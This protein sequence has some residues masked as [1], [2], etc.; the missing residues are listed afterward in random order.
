M[1]DVHTYAAYLS[2]DIWN[3]GG[4]ND[5]DFYNAKKFIDALKQKTV[6]GYAYIPVVTQIERLT[7]ENKD[8]AFGWAG[9]I[10]GATLPGAFESKTVLVPVPCSRCSSVEA[11]KTSNT[12]RLAAEIASVLMNT[13]V[14]PLLYL[15]ESM[16]SASSG[17]GSRDPEV[18]YPNIEVARVG[19]TRSCILIDDVMTTG[20]HLRACES[21]L[22][23]ANVKVD[24]AICIGRTVWDESVP[25]FGVMTDTLELYRP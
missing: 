3:S 18:L 13:S 20:G 11:V 12:F 4:P 1:F 21:R 16:P 9:R 8:N 24:C 15:R 23:R 10:V 5:S 2:G 7:D 6:N 25:P 17:G 19:F 14:E 22:H